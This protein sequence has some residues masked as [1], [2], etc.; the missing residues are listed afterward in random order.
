VLFRSRS[1]KEFTSITENAKGNI[2]I[3]SYNQGYVVVSE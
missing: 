2:L 1:I 3:H